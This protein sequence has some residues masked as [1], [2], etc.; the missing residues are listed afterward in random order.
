MFP[1]DTKESGSAAFVPAAKSVEKSRSY[2]WHLWCVVSD[3]KG[4][5]EKG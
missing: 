1:Y 4:G 2:V 3:G 5:R